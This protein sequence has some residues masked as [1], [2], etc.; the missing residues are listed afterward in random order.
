MYYFRWSINF[1][2]KILDK[3]EAQCLLPPDPA[4][5][6][7]IPSVLDFFQ[8]KKIVDVAEVNQ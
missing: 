6:G 4:A 8:R 3:G 1:N 5:P 2:Q 7:L